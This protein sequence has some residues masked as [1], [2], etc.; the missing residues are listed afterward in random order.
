ML[1]RI[2]PL[3]D[4]E[5]KYTASVPVKFFPVMVTRESAA[6]ELG[7]RLVTIGRAA[8]TVSVAAELVAEPY[9]L[10]KTARYSRPLS[11]VVVFATVNVA[12]VFPASVVSLVNVAPPFVDTCHETVGAGEPDAA[13]VKV[14]FSPAVTVLVAGFVVTFGA[15]V[16]GLTVSVAAVVVAEPVAFVNTAR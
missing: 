14:A 12:V 13:A 15:S 16:F 3:A 4:F 9:E 2:Q 8:L 6:P 1:D 11:V 7:D 10:V 5:P